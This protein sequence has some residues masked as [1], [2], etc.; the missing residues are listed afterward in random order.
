MA[1]IGLFISF[2]FALAVAFGIGF[3]GAKLSEYL[4]NKKVMKNAND[5]LIGKRKNKIELDDG[6]ILDVNKFIVPTENQEEKLYTEFDLKGGVKT[7]IIKNGKTK[8]RTRTDD[9]EISIGIINRNKINKGSV[10][11]KKRDIRRRIFR[12]FG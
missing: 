2:I 1:L 7:K 11:E 4:S 6:R 9:R 12:R 10:R 3:L 5:F 8:T